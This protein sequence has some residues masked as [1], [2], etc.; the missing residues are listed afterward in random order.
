MIYK[1]N[2]RKALTYVIVSDSVYIKGGLVMGFEDLPEIMTVSEL[3]D[4]VRVSG[5]TVIRALKA[6]QLIGFK[7]GKD[8]RIERKE[9]INW[10]D[11][12]TYRNENE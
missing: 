1:R 10:I 9:V 12:N 4:Y 2:F 3:A 7:V 11:R 5:Q 8:W 6:G